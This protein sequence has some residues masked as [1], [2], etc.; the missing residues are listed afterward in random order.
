MKKRH[1][2]EIA[3]EIE[4]GFEISHSDVMVVIEKAKE[5]W[6]NAVVFNDNIPVKI[7]KA[8]AK[9]IMKSQNKNAFFSV[10][11]EIC[12]RVAHFGDAVPDVF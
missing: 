5:I 3:Q 2:V 11:F 10:E 8:K 12:S 6:V 1:I 9:E 4:K 7:S